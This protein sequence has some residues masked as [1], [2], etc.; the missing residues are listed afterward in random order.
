MDMGKPKIRFKGYGDDWEQRKLGDVTEFIRNGYSY[1]ADGKR[2]HRYKITRIESISSGI[3]NTDKLGSS[4]DINENYKLIDGDILFSHINSLPYIANTAIYTADFGEIYHGMNLLNIRAK[5]QNIVPYFLLHLLKNETSRKW[6]RLIAKPAVNQASISTIEVCAFEFLLPKLEEQKKIANFLNTL[7]HLITLHQRKYE[8]AK[9]L[10]KYMLQKMFP[11]NGKKVPEIRFAGFT[12]DWEQRKVL[13]IAPLQRGFDLPS[14]D[15]KQGKY[16]VVM[17]NGIGSYHSEYKAKG[18]GV[19]TGRSGTIGKLHYIEDNYWP[20]NTALWVTDFKGNNPK[21]VYYMFQCID[22][23][24]FS[25]GS[26]VPTLNRNDVHDTV[27]SIPSVDEQIRISEYL[28]TLD[29]LITLH[30]RKQEE[31]KKV[32]KYMLEKMFV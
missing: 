32:K 27:V 30:Q 6:F 23:S 31:L 13:D 18:P 2:N 1:K 10:K 29:H 12:D 15:I 17:S 19:V 28:T 22:L 26:G 11:Q 25:T 16:P 7:D 20:H 9:K 4:E 14:T 21:F 24:R 3:I 8:D 5:S